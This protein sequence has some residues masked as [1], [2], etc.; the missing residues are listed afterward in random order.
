MINFGIL[1]TSD[2]TKRSLIGAADEIPGIHI[3][4]VASRDLHRASAY[5]QKFD[6]PEFYGDYEKVINHPNIQA[7]YMPLV[8][9]IHAEWIIKAIKA[10][11]HV[12]VEK[13]L[14]LTSSEVNQIE[15][16]ATNKKVVVMEGMMSK[17]HS[18]QKDLKEIIE[19]KPYGQLISLET[20]SQYILPEDD[21]SFRTKP[22]LGGGVFREEGNVWIQLVQ[23]VFGL[24]YQQKQLDANFKDG[25]DLSFQCQLDYGNG[26][27]AKVNCAYD[28]P[29]KAVHQLRFE[30]TTI[31]VQNFWRP[32]FG[33][34]KLRL[35]YT[36]ESHSRKHVYAAENYYVNQL[37]HFL[38]L[39]DHPQQ[40]NLELKQAFQR[41][42]LTESLYGSVEMAELS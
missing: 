15:K 4:A 23:L 21:I 36:S 19:K 9:S 25:V 35:N 13:P 38:N 39:L 27:Y 5:A 41:V 7:I 37:Q 33:A 22:S 42:Q 26:R 31:T 24:A 16:E 12:L 20:T 1:G 14:C 17:F 40:A 18:W 34:N 30:E 32:T 29:Y 6:I 28:Q 10:D 8:P 2:L 11:K 3:S